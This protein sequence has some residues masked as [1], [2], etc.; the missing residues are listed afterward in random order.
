MQV[1]LKGRP[2]YPRGTMTRCFSKSVSKVLKAACTNAHKSSNSVKVYS[3][4]KSSPVANTYTSIRV[5]P[6]R[7]DAGQRSFGMVGKHEEDVEGDGG[8]DESKLAE[9]HNQHLRVVGEVV[10]GC[11]PCDRSAA[12]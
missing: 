4:P 9:R 3:T 5:F 7:Q 11:S 8:H 1:W 10:Y 6:S 2:F 12:R